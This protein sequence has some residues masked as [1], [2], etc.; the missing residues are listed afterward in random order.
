MC[1]ELDP[2]PDMLC[3]IGALLFEVSVYCTEQ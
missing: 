3:G 2:I 1:L